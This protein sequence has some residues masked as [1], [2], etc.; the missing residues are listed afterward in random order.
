[1][2]EDVSGLE[3]EMGDAAAVGVADRPAERLTEPQRLLEIERD[4]APR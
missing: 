2:K 1:M 4:G 3:V